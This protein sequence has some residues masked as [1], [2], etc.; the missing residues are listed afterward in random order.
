MK[1]NAYCANACRLPYF[2]SHR[3][4]QRQQNLSKNCDRPASSDVAAFV[5]LSF[6]CD[7]SSRGFHP[8]RYAALLSTSFQPIHKI[9]LSHRCWD[10]L[11][12]VS[13]YSDSLDDKNPYIP[14]Q[15]TEI[16]GKGKHVVQVA[17]PLH[18]TYWQSKTPFMFLILQRGSRLVQQLLSV[19]NCKAEAERLQV[20]Q[21]T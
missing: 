9:L 6:K 18:Y 12:Y 16:N 5:I 1:I 20:I 10:L 11:P 4:N 15:P 3:Q 19:K 13:I 17:P 2:P 14:V 8:Q 21:R 7:G